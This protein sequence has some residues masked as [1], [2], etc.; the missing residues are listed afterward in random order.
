MILSGNLAAVCRASIQRGSEPRAERVEAFEKFTVWWKRVLRPE[1]NLEVVFICNYE[2]KNKCELNCK[3]KDSITLMSTA[4]TIPISIALSFT[5][6]SQCR[7]YQS[8]PRH[9]QIVPCSHCDVLC[10]DLLCYDI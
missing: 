5:S 3:G 4:T 1:F 6:S 8:H 10:H 7:Q 2:P 9:V